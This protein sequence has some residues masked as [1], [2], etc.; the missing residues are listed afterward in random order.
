MPSHVYTELFSISSLTDRQLSWFYNLAIMN[1]AMINSCVELPL[2][3]TDLA[4]SLVNT[5]EWYSFLRF[6]ELLIVLKYNWAK[7]ADMILSRL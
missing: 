6:E 7:G 4:D 2:L 1:G 3:Y 5:Q